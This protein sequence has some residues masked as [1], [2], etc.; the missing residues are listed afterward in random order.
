MNRSFF[1]FLIIGAVVGLV[2][3]NV[4]GSPL[5]GMGVGLGIALAAFVVTRRGSGGAALSRGGTYDELLS[6]ARGDAS[7]VERL[8]AFEEKRNPNGTRQDW[9]ADALDRWERD[10]G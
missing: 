6:K 5:V 3:S 9:V 1:Y 7:L 8:I 4:V 2:L 10:R